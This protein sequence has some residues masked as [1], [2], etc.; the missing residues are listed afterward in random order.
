MLGRNR[1]GLHKLLKR[2]DFLSSGKE[3]ERIADHAGFGIIESELFGHEKGSFT[4][5]IMARQGLFETAHGGTIFLDELGELSLSAQT[6]LLR[7][8]N[9]RVVQ[10]LGSG[11]THP[12]DF[13]LIA[14][15]HIAPGCWAQMVA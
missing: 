1:C 7:V 5:A 12:V 9:D 3:P 2:E 8:L 4:G 10:R 14:A 15:A 6:R 11:K 13:R